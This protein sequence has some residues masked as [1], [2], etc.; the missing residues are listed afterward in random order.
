MNDQIFNLQDISVI[1]YPQE[2]HLQHEDNSNSMK[3]EED[4]DSNLEEGDE[5]DYSC[6]TQDYGWGD[7]NT[8]IKI[9]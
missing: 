4:I 9:C 2:I 1:A 8:E 7:D 5:I 3:D 6:V